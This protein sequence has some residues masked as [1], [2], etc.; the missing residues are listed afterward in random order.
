MTP[1]RQ[2]CAP[3]RAAAPESGI[4]AVDELRPRPRRA[5]PALGR[6]GRPADARL[7]HRRGRQGAA[8]RRDL[9]HLAGAA[10]RN[11]ARRLPATTPRHFGKSFSPRR[12]HRHR[13]AA[14][15]RSSW[16][17]RRSPA[18]A[19]RSIY[20]SP[21]WPN[22][23]AAAG[24][25]GATPVAVPLDQ[26]ATMAG[27]ATSTSSR[28]RSR[29]APRRIFVNTPSNPTGWTADHE[30]LAGDPRSRPRSKGLWIIADEIY[31][32][33]HYG[34]GRA[35]SFLDIMDA[36]RPH[37]V[38]QH[39]LQEL[40]DDRLARRLDQ[41]ASGAA[42]G[43]REPDPVFDLGRRA[44]HA[45][46]RR[47]RARRGRRLHRRAGGAGAGRRATSSAASS[48]PP[49]RRASPC[50]PARS[51]C[52][53]RST[54]SPI[55]RQAAFDIVDQANVGLAPGTAFGAGRRGAFCG[56][57]STAASTRS[58]KP[59]TGWHAGSPRVEGWLSV[60]P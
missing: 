4:V 35:P 54:A 57:A 38:R 56:S 34:G 45:A 23:A 28:P 40:G 49:A 1:D 42:A 25:A 13:L 9:L 50:R 26:S 58:R 11:C 36:G 60:C 18:P 31:A 46:R 16:R 3:K 29:R 53:S 32:L 44:V 41:D 22:F 15:R 48:A 7:H 55:A 5:D 33:F 27:P 30:T 2:L 37:P 8:R 51:I 17:C 19:T 59:R 10:F 6:R 12:I 14:C 24:V 39:L 47:C 20:L 21:A 43:V 52:S